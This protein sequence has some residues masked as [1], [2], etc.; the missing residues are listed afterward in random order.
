M[1][2]AL[3]ALLIA[4]APAVAAPPSAASPVPAAAIDPARLAEAIRL[5]DAEGFEE[6]VLNSSEMTLE[7]MLAAMTE[8]IQNRTS[9]PVPED[10]LNKLRHE[11]R[12]HSNATLRANMAAMKREAGEIYA[13]EFSREELVRL[14]ELAAEPVMVKARARNKVIGPKLM[15]I[16]VRMMREAQPELDA[17]IQRLV[18]EYLDAAKTAAPDRS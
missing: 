2:A 16:G 6:E 11:M 7:V 17:R 1:V 14:R 15:M 4:A 12:A 13:R 3:L 10:F 9:E 5:L 18:A 8:Q